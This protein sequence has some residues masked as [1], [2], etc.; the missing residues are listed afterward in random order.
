MKQADYLV[1]TLSVVICEC[2]HCLYAFPLRIKGLQSC[3]IASAVYSM[4]DVSGLGLVPSLTRHNGTV[5]LIVT[6]AVQWVLNTFGTL[7]TV[8]AAACCPVPGHNRG[9]QAS[10]LCIK[11]AALTCASL[12]C[13]QTL[14]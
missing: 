13:I 3:E 7:N 8:L 6:A 9:E 10:E 12:F 14:L 11:P 5:L 1:G 2:Q 4:I